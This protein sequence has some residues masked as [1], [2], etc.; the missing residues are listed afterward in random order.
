MFFTIQ[1]F[2]QRGWGHI[3]DKVAFQSICDSVRFILFSRKEL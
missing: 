2:C 1:G 3:W